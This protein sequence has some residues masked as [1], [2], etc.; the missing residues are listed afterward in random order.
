V[1]REKIA[2]VSND[3]VELVL[4]G[5]QLWNREDIDSTLD[6]IH[7]DIEWRPGDVFLDADEVCRG[8]DGVRRFWADFM[9]PFE[10]ISL[11]PLEQEA[12]GD[13]VVIRGRFL[14]RGRQGITA[15]LEVYQRYTFRA[16]KLA[17]FE[18]YSSWD[19]A[20]AAAGLPPKT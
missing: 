4:R 13:E 16:G 10:A 20:L 12:A 1:D 8:H 9:G 3:N 14:A 18:A 7:P 6:L 11:E 15:D 5:L 19:E 2:A 17:R